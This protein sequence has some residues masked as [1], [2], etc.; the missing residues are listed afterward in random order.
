MAKSVGMYGLSVKGHR[1]AV[2]VERP[3]VYPRYQL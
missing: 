2:L 3:G 1:V